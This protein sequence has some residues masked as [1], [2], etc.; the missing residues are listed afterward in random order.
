LECCYWGLGKY[1]WFS[2]ADMPDKESAA[3]I[4]LAI[5]ATGL[6]NVSAVG[7]LT[8]E[9]MDKVAKKSPTYRGPGQ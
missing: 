6:G 1:G 2:I 5:N 8:A 9:E 4:V 3:S 7:L